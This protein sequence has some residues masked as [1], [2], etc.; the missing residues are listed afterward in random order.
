MAAS[1]GHALTHHPGITPGPLRPRGCPPTRDTTMNTAF[2]LLAQYDARAIIPLELV[3]RDYF[4]HL[5]PKKLARKVTEG[6]IALPIV[7]IDPAS[8]KTALGVHV[9]DLADWIDRQRAR[10][11]K[12]VAQLQ[13]T[14]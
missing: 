12:E 2:L 10:A 8:Q 11:Q 7:R 13:G 3:A 9:Q 14:A 1:T 5:D 6:E 4:S